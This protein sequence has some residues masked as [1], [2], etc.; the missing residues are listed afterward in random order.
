VAVLS[1]RSLAKAIWANYKITRDEQS[2]FF[3]NAFFGLTLFVPS[4][5]VVPFFFFFFFYYFFSLLDSP[6]TPSL[7]STLTAHGEILQGHV[8]H[9]AYVSNL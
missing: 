7:W 5:P 6:S 9:Q 8:Q 1:A 2:R 3:P 4:L